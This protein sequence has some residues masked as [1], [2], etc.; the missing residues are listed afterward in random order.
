MDK[1]VLGI[2]SGTDVEGIEALISKMEQSDFDYLKLEG[3]GIKIVI[4]KSGALGED[5]NPGEAKQAL[6]PAASGAA[7]P[8]AA[9]PASVWVDTS[10]GGQTP[11]T[12]APSAPKAAQTPEATA[13]APDRA[14]DSTADLTAQPGVAV[15]KSPSYGMFYAQPEP[16][17]PPYVKVGD[18][19]QKGDTIG[20][21]EIM[22]TY[23]AII[24]EVDGEVIAIHVKNEDILEPD[25]AMVSVRVMLT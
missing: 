4:S 10:Q 2:L 5:E 18:Q 9:A 8:G 19:V 3:E 15:I 25:Q 1:H 12:D 14:A 11:A 13:S 6:S 17:A 22:K 16:N 7:A 20:L 24:S 21:L 23:N